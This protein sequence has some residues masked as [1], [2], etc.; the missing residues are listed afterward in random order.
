M[1]TPEPPEESTDDTRTL[2]SQDVDPEAATQIQFGKEN[3][4]DA[5]Q[6]LNAQQDGK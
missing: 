5:T 3:T 6:I 2:L 4:E 1:E